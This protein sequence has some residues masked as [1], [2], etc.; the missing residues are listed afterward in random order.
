MSVLPLRREVHGRRPFRAAIFYGIPN[1]VLKQ[2]LQM[3]GVHRQRGQ[4]ACCDLS[5]AIGDS[6]REICQRRFQRLV[7]IDVSTESSNFVT[8]V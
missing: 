1:E 8:W 6:T 2:L 5:A 3:R 4:R 7:R